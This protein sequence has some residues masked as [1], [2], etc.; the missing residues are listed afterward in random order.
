MTETEQGY[1]LPDEYELA[2]KTADQ[3][4]EMAKSK[5]DDMDVSMTLSPSGLWLR[6]ATRWQSTCG[7]CGQSIGTGDMGPVT[8]DDGGCDGIGT[9]DFQHGCGHWNTPT[10]HSVEVLAE[11]ERALANPADDVAW[12]LDSLRDPF[13]GAPEDDQKREDERTDLVAALADHI[14]K[15]AIEALRAEVEAEQ[16][17]A[18]REATEGLESDADRIAAAL[19][20]IDPSDPNA[21]AA[22]ADLLDG[23]E[24]EPGSYLYRHSDGVTLI[25]WDYD[26]RSDHD[27]TLDAERPVPEPL[28]TVLQNR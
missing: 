14:L 28:A 25:V 1:E 2:E 5:R 15:G 23:S 26:P 3:L 24:I 21:D 18:A 8:W 7:G 16:E 6:V 19:A 17:Q 11:V 12:M 20:A 9:F 27:T 22:V 13:G 10:E 4:G